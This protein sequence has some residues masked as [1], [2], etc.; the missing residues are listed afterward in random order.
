MDILIV[1]DEPQIARL[2]QEVLSSYETLGQ[3][4]AK[5]AL[6]VLPEFRPDLILLDLTMPEMDG[7]EACKLIKEKF[8]YQSIY[9]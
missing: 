9:R 8:E 2:L 4:S 5:M 6:N 7:I 3:Q 1:D